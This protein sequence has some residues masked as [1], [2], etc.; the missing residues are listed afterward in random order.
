MNMPQ[1]LNATIHQSGKSSPEEAK[2]GNTG[3]WEQKTGTPEILIQQG[4]QEVVPTVPTVPT[5]KQSPQKTL[6][7]LPLEGGAIPSAGDFA[8]G[9]V[10]AL[11]MKQ[12]MPPA[13]LP[14]DLLE[15]VNL[16]CNLERWPSAGRA[17]WLG[18][19]RAQ[20][21]R[22]GVPVAE[23]VA[24]LDAHLN[25]HHAGATADD[26]REAIEERAAIMEHDGGLSRAEAE[27]RAKQANDCMNCRHWKGE[28]T[29]PDAR[30]RAAQMVGL[31]TPHRGNATQGMCGARYRPWRISNMASEA[32]YTRW[33]FI[34]QCAF[35]PAHIQEHAA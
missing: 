34:G 8:A 14:S 13:A 2:S 10:T 25:R 32:D 18:M 16:I 19:L 9:I 3:T 12:P 1:W 6:S 28:A 30:Q 15:R 33:H 20:I 31:Q 11:V 23:L 27:H 29:V 4:F 26:D 24:A 21:E 22:D 17:E 35:Q 7:S 5:E